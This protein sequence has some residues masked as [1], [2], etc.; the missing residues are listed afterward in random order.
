MKIHNTLTT[1]A[2]SALVA[3]ALTTPAFA[4]EKRTK[5]GV[6]ECEVEG[7]VGLL[8]GSSKAVA[9]S[10]KHANGTV[11]R[12]TGKSSKVGLDIGVTGKSYLS[13]LVFT[14]I[15]NKAGKH[16]LAG[17]YVGISAAGALGIGLGANALVGGSND[18]IGLQ[19]LSVEA[20]TGVNLALGVSSLT[21]EP[22][23]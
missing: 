4:D 15:G 13:W 12:Y 16:A 19:P 14:P 7:G 2:A 23:S 1:I 5:L 11:E 22:A 10:F 8:L 9:C 3:A 6:L 17:Q 20:G 21:L 18:K